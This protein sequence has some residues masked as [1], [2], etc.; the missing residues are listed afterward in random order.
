LVYV[1]LVVYVALLRELHHRGA[2]EP[3]E[4]PPRIT[5]VVVGH[6]EQFQR[7]WRIRGHCHKLVRITSEQGAIDET[8]Y[9][10]LAAASGAEPLRC[11]R[12]AGRRQ[13]VMENAV[14]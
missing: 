14:H 8:V 9:P 4:D 3:G 2:I 10:A 5:I 11:N 13:Y 1:H 6:R 7:P 12:C